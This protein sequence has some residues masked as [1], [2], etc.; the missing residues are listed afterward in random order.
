MPPKNVPH[1]VDRWG[2]REQTRKEIHATRVAH[3]KSPWGRRLLGIDAVLM[4][5][6]KKTDRVDAEVGPWAAV[7]AVSQCHGNHQVRNSSNVQALAIRGNKHPA[8]LKLL[9]LVI[10][11]EVNLSVVAF[12]TEKRHPQKNLRPHTEPRPWHP[13][14]AQPERTLEFEERGANRLAVVV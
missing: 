14:L 1:V 10:A 2:D 5:T 12:W 11:I 13:F 3:E 4:R 7:C 9:E 8:L 6:Q